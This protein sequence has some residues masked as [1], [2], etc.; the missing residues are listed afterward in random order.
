MLE[1]VATLLVAIMVSAVAVEPAHASQWELMGPDGGPIVSV[2]AGS[3]AA[4]NVY[5]LVSLGPRLF[6]S[7]DGGLHWSERPAPP[8]CTYA[9]LHKLQIRGDEELYLHCGGPILRS[10]DGGLTWAPYTPTT[11]D[12]QLAF[13]PFYSNRAAIGPSVSAYTSDDGK[14]WYRTFRAPPIVPWYIA[15]DPTRLNRILGVGT[16]TV[17]GYQ[18]SLYESLDFGVHWNAVSAILPLHPETPIGCYY[19][20][21]LTIGAAGRMFVTHD[22]GL[23]R[24]L[25]SGSTWVQMLAFPGRGTLSALST[26]PTD[27]DHLVAGPSEGGSSTDRLYESRDSGATWQTLPIPPEW[28]A[29]VAIG[30]AGDLWI[31]TEDGVHLYDRAARG[32]LSRNVGLKAHPIA[33]VEPA[34]GASLTLSALDGAYPNENAKQSP[35]GGRTWNAFKVNGRLAE[36]LSRNA[37][38]PSSLLATTSIWDTPYQLYAS[39]DGGISWRLAGQPEFGARRVGFVVAVGPQ[40][41]RVYGIYATCVP[42]MFEGCFWTPQ[43]MGRSDD[44]GASWADA[45]AG[46]QGRAEAI[47]ASPAD[48]DVAIVAANDG[49]YVTRDGARSWRRVTPTISDVFVA[50][51]RDAARWYALGGKGALA[52]TADYGASWTALSAAGITSDTFDLLIEPHDP[53]M[54]YAV[55]DGG[56]VSVSLD[57]GANWAQ[58][59]AA[60]PTSAIAPHSARLAPLL[61]ST[62]FAAGDRGVARFNVA[63]YQ[64]LWWHDPAGSESGWGLNL[65][66]QGDTIF[67][68]WFTYDTTGKATWFAM[69]A[70]RT[71]AGRYE[72]M[73]YRSRG[74]AFS[75]QPFDPAQVVPT[76]A[77]PATLTFADADHGVFTYTVDGTTQ[78]KPIVRE[79]FG[80][81]PTCIHDSM[82]NLARATN[83]QDMWWNAPAGSESGW[84]L[85]LAHEGDTLFATWFTYDVDG[86]PMWLVATAP[87]VGPTSYAGTLYRTSGP[88]FD[89]FDPAKVV[90]APVGTATLSLADGNTGTFAYVVSTAAGSA[91]GTKA[92]T[93]QIFRPPGTACQ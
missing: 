21:G 2:A 90:A 64:G 53:R 25:D 1:R 34:A 18:T 78:S 85:N 66:H 9:Y 12:G 52:A 47:V 44:G 10:R 72:G 57:Q 51:P 87:K 13:D 5:A 67:A 48:A 73:L 22:C 69:T 88:R 54:L 35:D 55:G 82:S 16:D 7:S 74:P 50:D 8:T 83:Y 46:I 30:G 4:G 58:I 60:T 37:S 68:T 62:I 56:E 36:R 91:S 49:V 17:A 33:T 61:S 11:L 27:P 63:N 31:A 79:V 70:D 86:T 93:R 19:E 24:S 41:G 77:G 81:L 59:A 89:A 75:A 76:P 45:N 65:A 23:F 14:Y 32:W 3:V 92:I 40:P 42:S 71:P 38:D 29:D 15:F 80:V 6:A 28:A 43:T 84:G 39:S 26:D 20:R